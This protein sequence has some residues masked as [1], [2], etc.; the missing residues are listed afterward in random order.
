MSPKEEESTIRNY[1]HIFVD[2]KEE[3]ILIKKLDDSMHQ[4]LIK[5]YLAYQPRDS[6]EGL[7]PIE[8]EAC[9]KWVWKMIRDGTNLVALASEGDIVGHA[10]IFFIDRQ[11]CE[12]L[13]VVWPQFQSRGIGTEL[14]RSSIHLAHEM[15]FEKVWLSVDAANLRA[16]HIYKECGFECLS[17]G[18]RGDVEMALDLKGQHKEEQSN[19]R[20]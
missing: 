3:A 19:P 8:D 12:M 18:D 20:L 11:R 10:A 17:S 6:F 5:K 15:G 16:R 9:V 4:A 13:T 1:S 14:V 2:R 7:P